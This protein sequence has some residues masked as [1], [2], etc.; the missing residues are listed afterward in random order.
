MHGRSETIALRPGQTL[1]LV[2]D[3]IEEY[4]TAEGEQFGSERL[5]ELLQSESSLSPQAAL[6]K[7]FLEVRKFSGDL[8]QRD[9]MTAILVK[10]AEVQCETAR[11]EK[12]MNLRTG[13][14][15]AV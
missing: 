14:D 7:L 4:T 12:L 6:E 10:V 8:P 9:D 13:H 3:G 11:G 5:I 1:V 15:S 2:T